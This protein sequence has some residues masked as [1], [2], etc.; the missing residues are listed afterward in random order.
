[1][2]KGRKTY[3]IPVT[4]ILI[5][6]LAEIVLTPTSIPVGGEADE[7]D[8]KKDKAEWSFWEEEE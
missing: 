2:V 1:M 5:L 3:V 6:Q 4:N 8:V 7:F